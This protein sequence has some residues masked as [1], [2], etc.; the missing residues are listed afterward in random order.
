MWDRNE[1][2]TSKIT[3]RGTKIWIPDFRDVGMGDREII[4]DIR[5]EMFVV[6]HDGRV[7]G[8]VR[9]THKSY[10]SVQPQYY[11]LLSLEH[12]H[13]IQKDRFRVRAHCGVPVL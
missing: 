3:L 5:D 2:N 9:R 7:V 12:G 6:H 8:Q 10:C 1:F 11:L 13:S 4:Q